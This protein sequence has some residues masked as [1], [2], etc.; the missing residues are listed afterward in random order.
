[1]YASIMDSMRSYTN[2]LGFFAGTQTNNQTF[3][4][5]LAVYSKA[6]V[7]DMKSYIKAK[8]YRLMGIGYYTFDVDLFGFEQNY[9]NCGDS[10]S[11]IDFLG[12]NIFS[13]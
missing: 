2:V 11:S 4:T 8:G 7:R 3:D 5:A 6:A 10:S 9:Y 1:M 12:L 13:W